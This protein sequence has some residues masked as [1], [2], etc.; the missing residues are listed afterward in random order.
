MSEQKYYLITG[1]VHN[2]TTDYNKTYSFVSKVNGAFWL[3]KTYDNLLPGC[4][5]VYSLVNCDEI[6][7]VMYNFL[8]HHIGKAIG[9]DDE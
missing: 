4:P 9:D 2:N 6:T 1:H 5:N 7:E 8:E 3:F